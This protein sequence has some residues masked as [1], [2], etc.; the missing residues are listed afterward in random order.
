MPDV[1]ELS[2]NDMSVAQR[3]AT[4]PDS[5]L[6]GDADE[7]IKAGQERTD[8]PEAPNEI[9][10][11]PAAEEEPAETEEVK[12]KEADAE[13]ETDP[14]F[15]IPDPDGGEARK[16]KLSELLEAEREFTAFK[17][18][19]AA[20]LTRVQTEASNEAQGMVQQTRQ[21]MGQIGYQL[22]AVLQHIQPP[23]PPPVDMLDPQSPRYNP[24]SYHLARAQFEQRAA[25]YQQVQG[26]AQWIEQQQQA[27]NAQRDDREFAKLAPHW[28]EFTDQAK[29][30]MVQQEFMSGMNKHYGF[31][32]A[33]LDSVMVDH[34][35][36]LVAR[37]AL[38]WREHEAK[39]KTAKTTLKEK[40]VQTAKPA[41]QGATQS[42]G[43]KLTTDQSNYMNARK[44]LKANG[45]D[46]NAAAKGFLRF[47]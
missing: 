39:A 14:E 35:Q 47:L 28:P 29:G 36:A 8:D 21:A 12:T 34:R 16:V 3:M 5:V 40:V 44:A 46:M 27:L 32:F 42:S 4:L 45:K 37:D 11:E 10:D 15:E 23:Q 1:Q 19:K 7:D 43:K 18:E 24:D 2:D 17:D 13:G 9:R 22:Q 38:K 31:T 20:I 41:K 33:E 25:S 30:P 26:T 6:F